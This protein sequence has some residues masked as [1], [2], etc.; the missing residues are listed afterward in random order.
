MVLFSCMLECGNSVGPNVLAMA[1]VMID[2]GGGS[3]SFIHWEERMLGTVGN[4]K[5]RE[6]CGCRDM[7]PYSSYG[8][9]FLQSE[10]F[11]EVKHL[12]VDWSSWLTNFV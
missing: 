12:G 9:N 7:W 4:L 8:R 11:V 3:V 1:D 10:G 6:T 5:R 2:R